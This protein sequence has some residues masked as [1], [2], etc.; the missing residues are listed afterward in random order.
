MANGKIVTSAVI[1]NHRFWYL[2]NLQRIRSREASRKLQKKVSRECPRCTD[3]FVGVKAKNLEAKG[4]KLCAT[5][6]NDPTRTVWISHYPR[7]IRISA[8]ATVGFDE[9]APFVTIV[10]IGGDVVPVSVAPFPFW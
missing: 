2:R 10:G 6:A 4:N 1:H 8:R 5:C 9:I 3:K 7:S